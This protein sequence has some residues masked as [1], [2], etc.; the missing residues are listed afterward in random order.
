MLA[1]AAFAITAQTIAKTP[2]AESSVEQNFRIINVVP[3]KTMHIKNT[4]C[5]EHTVLHY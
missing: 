3:F 2:V 4:R 5:T 1:D